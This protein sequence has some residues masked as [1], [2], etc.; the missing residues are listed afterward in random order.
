MNV[1]TKHATW[2][3]YQTVTEMES[4][5]KGI[6]FG[7]RGVAGNLRYMMLNSPV[8]TP[9]NGFRTFLNG[10]SAHTGGAKDQHGARPANKER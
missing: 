9:K 8:A 10:T 7:G 5:K 3:S 4:D 6:D 1:K 2:F